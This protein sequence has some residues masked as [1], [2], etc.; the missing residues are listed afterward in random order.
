MIFWVLHQEQYVPI[1]KDLEFFPPEL[2][3]PVS[4]KS[5]SKDTLVWLLSY[6][7]TTVTLTEDEVKHV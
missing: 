2:T 5:H 6:E 3:W 1:D 4:F 7:S